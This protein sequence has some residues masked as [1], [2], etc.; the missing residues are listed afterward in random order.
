MTL[1]RRHYTI[2]AEVIGS[3]EA[4]RIPPTDVRQV[5]IDDLL[6]GEPNFKRDK[7]DAHADKQ[8]D[9]IEMEPAHL[10][11]EGATFQ[12]SGLT[13][14][15]DTVVADREGN[16]VVSCNIDGEHVGWDG[17]GARVTFVFPRDYRI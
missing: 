17:E 13:W 3:I 12:Y 9:A 8:R 6:D 5:I 1:Q 2:L 15:A 4:G 10:L 14:R 7:F 11:K 16:I